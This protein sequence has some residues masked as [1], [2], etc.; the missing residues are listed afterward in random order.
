[1]SY[2]LLHA[3]NCVRFCFWHSATFLFVY[4]IYREPLEGYASN[5]QGRRVWSLARK[6]LNVKVKGQKSRSPGTKTRFSAYISGIAELI[7]EKFTRK[8][9]LVPRLDVLEG[10][11]QFWRPACGLCLEKHL[12]CT[13]KTAIRYNKDLATFVA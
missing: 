7:R 6:S 10:Q 11:G 12:C 2:L 5:S 1:M 4:E 13:T 3:V 8:T 9:C